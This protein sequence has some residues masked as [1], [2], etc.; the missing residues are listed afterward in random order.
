MW[1]SWRV[2]MTSVRWLTRRGLW[3]LLPS[4]FGTVLSRPLGRDP[5]AKS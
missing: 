4:G 3:S 1:P 2:A 5:D